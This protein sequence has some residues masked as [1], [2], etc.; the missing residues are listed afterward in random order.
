MNPS[1]GY[2]EI[3]AEEAKQFQENL[4]AHLVAGK[5]PAASDTNPHLLMPIGPA[6]SGK[7]TVSRSMIEHRCSMA[8]DNYAEMDFDGLEQFLPKAATYQAVLDVEG[9]PTTVNYA[10]AWTTTLNSERLMA[11][12]RT[13]LARLMEE[14]YYLIVQ[15]HDF[16]LLQ[17]AQ[18]YN[19]VC[20]LLYVAVTIGT[21]TKRAAQRAIALGRFL[22]G[23]T[24]ENAWGWQGVIQN[25]YQRYRHQTP[26]IAQWADNLIVVVNEK[27]DARPGHDDFK[28]L[29]THPPLEAEQDWRSVV[30]GL[31]S[32]IREAHEAADAI[33]AQAD[34]REAAV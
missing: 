22:D 11:A 29:V 34:G 4:Y 30:A 19:Y 17:V 18:T 7:S 10:L 3:D 28:A 8:A 15:S 32:E 25:Q 14:R 23:A 31:A 26:W 12:A 16:D 13:V 6:G 21:A 5:T 1:W 20:T 33:S 2:K 9:R 24:A 27:N